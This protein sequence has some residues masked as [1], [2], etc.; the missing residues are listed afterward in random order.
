V[1]ALP[2]NSDVGLWTF[3]GVAGR[4]EVPTGPLD[5]PVAGQPRSSVLTNNLNGQL[6]SNGGAVSFTTLRLAYNDANANFRE[7]Q[8]NSVLVITT[9]PHTD[10][11]LDGPGLQDFIRQTFNQ[12]KPVAVDVVDFGGD[13]DRAT[14]EAVAQTT[15]GDYQNLNSS[16]G[17]EL[18][19]TL[20]TMLG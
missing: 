20:A 15:G 10:Q 14:W 7:G 9:G 4:S 1:Q 2:P 8:P 12:G 11:S 18:T 17:P 19:T 13:P 3:D 5:E 16:V 6:A